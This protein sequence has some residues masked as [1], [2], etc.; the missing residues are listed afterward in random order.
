MSEV[1]LLDEAQLTALRELS[2]PGENFLAQLLRI[3]EAQ[4]TPMI[5]QISL[6]IRQQQA[7]TLELLAHKLKGSASNLGAL[8]L[9]EICHT[10]EHSAR[11]RLGGETEEQIGNLKIIFEATLH[12][13]R[14]EASK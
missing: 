5:E 6:A 9:S 1:P 14:S 13:L 7:R 12:A 4:S 11:A 10:L 8:R 2:S 3:F